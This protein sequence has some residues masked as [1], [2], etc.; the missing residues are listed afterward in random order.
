MNNLD[1]KNQTVAI[2]QIVQYFGL[3]Y[4]VIDIRGE[5]DT[6][7]VRLYDHAPLIGKPHIVNC[8]NKGWKPLTDCYIK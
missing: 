7:E 8:I 4:T 2:D 6:L 5:G 1:V 3:D